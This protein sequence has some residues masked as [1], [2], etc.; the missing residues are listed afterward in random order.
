MSSHS[1]RAFLG[2]MLDYA[3][4]AHAKV[5]NLSH[6]DWAG[7]EDVRLAVAYLVQIVGEAASRLSEETRA[8]LP[9]L[10]WRQM[11]GLRNRLVHGY[12]TI[13]TEAIWD[14]A[15]TDLPALIAT[16][17]QINLSEP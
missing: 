14:V 8:S 11:I 2:D 1:E 16:L 17:E 4:R 12:G 15:K 3:R 9:D 7:D 5:A 10:P 13:R 6:D